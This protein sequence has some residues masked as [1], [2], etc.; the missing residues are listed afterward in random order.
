MTQDKT[1]IRLVKG[2]ND[3]PEKAFP[4]SDVDAITTC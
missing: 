4:K 3:T 1:T 2:A